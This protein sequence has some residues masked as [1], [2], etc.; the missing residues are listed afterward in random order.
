MAKNNQ[1]SF[2]VFLLI[3]IIILSFICLK[4]LPFK[5]VRPVSYL[6]FNDLIRLGKQAYP[7]KDLLLKLN[8]QLN[9]PY[10]QNTSFTKGLNKNSIRIAQWNI[11]RGINIE[12]IKKVFSDKESYYYSYKNNLTKDQEEDL[13]RE[14][15]TLSNSDIITLNEVDIGLPRTK[16][17]NIVSEISRSLNYNYA[18]ATEFVELSPLIYGQSLDKK[19]YLGLHGN[20]V[21]SRYPIKSAWIVRLPGCY[22]WYESEI[23]KQSPLE[24]GRRFSAKNVFNVE[25]TNEV[26]HGSR[27]A[28][29]TNIEL[30]TKETITVISTHLEDKCYPSCRLKQM[31]YLLEN[32]KNIR[33]PLVLAGDLNTSTTDTGPASLTKEFSKRIKD[34]HF[35]SRQLALALLPIG[36]PLTVNLIS[37]IVG[38]T[39][40][41]KDPAAPSIPVLFPNQ[42]KRL[43]NY[44]KEFYFN[45]GETFNFGGE[46]ERSSNGKRGLLANSNERQLKGFESTFRFE[47]SYGIAYFKLDWFFVKPKRGRFEPFNGS[48]LKLVN[49]SCPNKISDHDPITVDLRI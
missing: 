19:K 7:E 28:L 6:S 38:K 15:N 32:I 48:T 11:E 43:F 47:R 13:R 26:R 16:Y 30:P 12:A 3:F 23:N 21:L 24:Y 45:D 25:I 14:L 42:E 31:E 27:C 8:K 39:L 37:A 36:P 22:R 2:L 5:I 9:I 34:P 40:Q 46:P 29:I 35:V 10:V 18:F 33:S 49:E 20:A 1:K 44:L 4:N 41:Y 17:K